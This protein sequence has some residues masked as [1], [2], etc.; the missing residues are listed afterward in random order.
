MIGEFCQNKQMG[1]KTFF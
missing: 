1:F